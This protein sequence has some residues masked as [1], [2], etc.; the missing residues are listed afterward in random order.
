MGLRTLLL[1]GFVSLLAAMPAEACSCLRH[2]TAREQ[3]ESAD[4]VFVGRV[5]HS[6]PKADPRPLWRR[7]IDWRGRDAPDHRHQITT[8]QV[9]ASLKGAIEGDIAIR[10]LPG[11]HSATCGV[12]FD[13]RQRRVVLAWQ[14]PEGGY[15]TSACHLP[16]FSEAE[17]RAGI[18]P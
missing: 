1:A 11:V 14:R 12:D 8:F 10:H 16:Q 13:G 2:D 4:I 7:I 3:V 17:F 9:D 18:A 15:S 5:I 6:G